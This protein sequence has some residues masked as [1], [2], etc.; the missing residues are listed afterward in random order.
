MVEY[1]YRRGLSTI[2]SIQSLPSYNWLCNFQSQVRICGM[3]GM[4]ILS[5]H[6]PDALQL[7]KNPQQ[8]ASVRVQKSGR[9]SFATSITRSITS[10]WYSSFSYEALYCMTSSDK[11]SRSR[12]HCSPRDAL[13]HILHHDPPSHL[14]ASLPPRHP[15]PAQYP[16]PRRNA[17]LV[18]RASSKVRWCRT[19]RPQL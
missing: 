12:L 16:F 1:L 6:K 15:F 17:P 4:A 5:G 13:H 11:C 10:E 19:R 18:P 8:F 9:P 7:Y 3:P 14:P 2:P